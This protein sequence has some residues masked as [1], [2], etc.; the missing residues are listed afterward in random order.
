MMSVTIKVEREREREGKSVK[1]IINYPLSFKISITNIQAIIIEFMEHELRKWVLI[2]HGNF[3]TM[4]IL[5]P[6]YI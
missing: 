3:Y 2:I 5:E 4:T 1:P 6:H